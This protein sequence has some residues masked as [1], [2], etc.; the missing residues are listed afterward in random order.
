VTASGAAQGTWHRAAVSVT[1]TATDAGSGVAAITY[2]LDGAETTVA[3]ASTLVNV[4]AAPNARHTLTYH[5]TDVAANSSA[6]K[7]LSFT[8][9]TSGPTTAGKATSGRRGRAIALRYKVT[10][11]LSPKATAIRIVVKNSRGRAV[12]TMKP[13]AR[14][15]AVWYAAKWTPRARGTYRYYVYAKDLAGNAQRKVGSAKV[16]VR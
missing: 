2:V 9:D 1:L 4:A 13:T 15:T 11:N 8:I 7:T 6:E 5:A 14:N 16:V 12:K 10:D 3:A